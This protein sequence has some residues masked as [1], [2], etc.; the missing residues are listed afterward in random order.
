[1]FQTVRQQ[2]FQSHRLPEN[3]A[4][5]TQRG[6]IRTQTEQQ[7]ATLP[8]DMMASGSSASDPRPQRCCFTPPDPTLPGEA[9][10][11]QVRHRSE[12]RWFNSWPLVR[13]S[14][15][16]KSELLTKTC[17]RCRTGAAGEPQGCVHQ[18]IGANPGQPL[19]MLAS[20]ALSLTFC[21][22]NLTI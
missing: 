5:A 12:G 4:M 18:L 1:M 21:A 20:S 7:V 22:L 14:R 2:C 8:S 6:P 9:A 13:Q 3:V 11:A 19:K 15:R 16:R 10:G 17:L